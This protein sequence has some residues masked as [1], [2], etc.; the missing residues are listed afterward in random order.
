MAMNQP[1]RPRSCRLAEDQVHG[2][3]FTGEENLAMVDCRSP[4]LLSLPLQASKDMFGGSGCGV[5]LLPA[6]ELE[7]HCLMYT[8][9]S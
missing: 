3:S 9:T 5:Q 4:Q 8:P 7:L 2:I 6:S 1:H